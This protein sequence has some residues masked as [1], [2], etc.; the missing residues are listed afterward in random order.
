MKKLIIILL[1]A[2]GVYTM[3][4]DVSVSVVSKAINNQSAI[5]AN[6]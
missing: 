5:L 3:A 1:M 4:Q 6:I 2:F